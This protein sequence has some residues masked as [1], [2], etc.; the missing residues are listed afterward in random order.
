MM[1]GRNHFCFRTVSAF[2]FLP[3]ISKHFPSSIMLP[4][5]IIGSHG[6]QFLFFILQ[7]L[8]KYLKELNNY[9]W[10][11]ILMGRLSHK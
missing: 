8:K 2:K 6:I 4:A 10:L 9:G 7:K 11:A 1:Q 5:K 3:F